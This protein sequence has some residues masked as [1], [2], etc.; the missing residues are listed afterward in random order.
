[1]KHKIPS[2]VIASKL[3]EW[4]SMIR[5]NQVTDAEFLKSEIQR[6]LDDMEEDQTVLVYYSLLELRH[7]MMLNDLKPATTVDISRS[8]SEIEVNMKNNQVDEMINYYFWFFKGMYE[9]KQ[10]NYNQAITCYKIAEKKLAYVKSEEEK[11]EFHYKLSEI[12]Y[13]LR[14]NY[15]SM[16]Y[17]SL[18]LETF[19]AY[20]TLK[21]KAIYCYFIIAGNQV[22]SMRYE[23]A[24]ENL[25]KALEEAKQTKNNLLIASALFNLGNCHFYLNEF[26]EAL[27][28]IEKSL[29]I[30]KNNNSPY[31]PKALFQMMYVCLKQEKK[32]DALKLYE[33]G[34]EF[35][36]KFNDQEHEAQLGILKGLYLDGFNRELIESG[37]DYLASKGLYIDLEELALDGASYYNKIGKLQE[38]TEL[39]QKGI[40]ANIHIKRGDGVL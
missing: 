14:Q 9:F 33:Q 39:Y 18:A 35:A 15:L 12:Y 7:Q 19:K 32:N 30:F 10:K 13:H 1:M 38:A 16:N 26:S 22:D 2:E 34:I 20:E 25:T 29:F 6:E 3:N 37:F 28:H 17:A 11:A 8:L 36:K 5:K 27:K 23:E 24:L 4:C 40:Q 21:E 31:I